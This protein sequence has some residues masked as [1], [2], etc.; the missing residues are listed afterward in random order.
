MALGTA[1]AGLAYGALLSIFPSLTS[2]YYGMKAFGNNY[3]VLYTAWGLAGAIGP[4]I[5]A[6]VMDANGNFGQAYIISAVLL[7]GTLIVTFLVKP[8]KGKKEAA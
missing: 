4:V 3:G 7:I 5:A 8:I 1:A 6:T 2:D